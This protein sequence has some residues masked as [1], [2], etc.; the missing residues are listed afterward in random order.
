M[1]LFILARLWARLVFVASETALFQ[2]RLAHAWYVA[3]PIPARPAP[4]TVDMSQSRI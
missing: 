3:R 2:S 4:A 1:Q